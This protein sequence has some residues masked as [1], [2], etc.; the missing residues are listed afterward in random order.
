MLQWIQAS[1]WRSTESR[2]LWNISGISRTSAD[3]ALTRAMIPGETS[4]CSVALTAWGF[5]HLLIHVAVNQAIISQN[6]LEEGEVLLHL[7]NLVIDTVQLS[8]RGSFVHT[9]LRRIFAV[10]HSNVYHVDLLQP[11]YD[12]HAY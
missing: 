3:A 11:M 12:C 7:G 10:Y 1:H 2:T 5:E 9:L 6:R 4:W 8:D